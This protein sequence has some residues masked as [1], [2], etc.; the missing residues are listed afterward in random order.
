MQFQ[1]IASTALSLLLL[2]IATGVAQ[3]GT[4]ITWESFKEVEFD[5]GESSTRHP[6]LCLK[7]VWVTRA[8]LS[9]ASDSRRGEI[10]S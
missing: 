5:F 10:I 8:R 6:K 7:R 1:R 9:D 4:A 3:E 2:L